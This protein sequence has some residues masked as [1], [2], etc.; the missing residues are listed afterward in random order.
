MRVWRLRWPCWAPPPQGTSTR[1]VSLE[2]GPG[3]ARGLLRGSAAGN[4]IEAAGEG[5]GACC[6]A[7][8]APGGRRTNRERSFEWG[9]NMP[10]EPGEVRAL[11][12]DERQRALHGSSLS[13]RGNPSALPPR[14]PT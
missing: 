3:Q 13:L 10:W 6:G 11:R 5:G 2:E 12:R 8:C 7:R 14:G 1:R 4:L 9:A